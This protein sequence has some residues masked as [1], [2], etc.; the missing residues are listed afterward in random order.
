MHILT[1]YPLKG[2]ILYAVQ[3]I[4]I[5][6]KISREFFIKSSKTLQLPILD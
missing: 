3:F 1:Y 4:V 5:C 2:K 6:D